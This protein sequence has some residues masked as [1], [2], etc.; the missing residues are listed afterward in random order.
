MYRQLQL[1]RVHYFLLIVESLNYPEAGLLKYMSPY[2]NVARLTHYFSSALY[3]FNLRT[4]SPS[5]PPQESR[6]SQQLPL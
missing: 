1:E 2:H 4:C 3:I 5:L 6:I